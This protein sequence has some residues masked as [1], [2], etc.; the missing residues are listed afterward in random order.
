MRPRLSR[1]LF[2][3]RTATP[4]PPPPSTALKYGR[5]TMRERRNGQSNGNWNTVRITSPSTSRKARQPSRHRTAYRRTRSARQLDKNT[6][7]DIFMSHPVWQPATP[8]RRPTSHHRLSWWTA[9][10]TSI[11]NSFPVR[12]TRPGKTRMES[13]S[14]A[15]RQSRATNKMRPRASKRLWL[16]TRQPY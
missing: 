3:F 9:I 4:P 15:Y 6:V 8:A 10:L 5:R 1:A 16:R 14:R 7:A 11:L 2:E 13:E 12:D